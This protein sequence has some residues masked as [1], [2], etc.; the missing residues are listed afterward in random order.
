MLYL[1]HATVAAAAR[2]RHDIRL[3]TEDLSHPPRL[4][5]LGR[6]RNAGGLRAALHA[7]QLSQVVGVP[8]GQRGLRR[9]LVPGAGG[10]RR[11]HRTE[12][13]FLECAVGDPGG[14]A[15]H[16]P[17][18]LA[19]LVLRG[20]PRRGHGPAH[21]RC[22]LRLPGLHAHLADLRELHLHLL[23]ARSGHPRA[24]AADVPRL[25]AV[26]AVP[27]VVDRDHSAGGARHHADFGA[28]A[29]DAAD[30]DRAVRLPLHRGDG[31]EARAVCRLHR[32]RGPH[33]GQQRLRSTDVRRC[34]HGGLLARGAD[35][36][37]GR[38]PALS[39]REDCRQPRALVDGRAGRRAGL[40]RAGHAE[41]DGRR[42]PGLP[43][44]AARDTGQPRDRAHADVPHGLFVRA[45]RP[46]LGA[47]HHGAV[48]RR[49]ADEDQP[50][51]RLCGLAGVVELLC[52]A[53]AQPPGARGVA[54]VQ[55]GHRDPADGAGRVRRAGARAG[56]LQQHRHR[57]GRRAR[58]RPGHQQAAGLEPE[59]H[60]VQARAPVRHQPRGPGRD[61]GGGGVGDA[62]L[63]GRARPVGAGLLALHRAGHGHGRVAPAR[64]ADARAL[65]PGTY[66][67]R[68]LDA[69]PE[70]E[71]LGV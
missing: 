52:A 2:T 41:D 26:A 8:R 45:A 16:L 13:R 34:R 44:A 7:A 56:L 63:F 32:A 11:R 43:G 47:G 64:M 54:G 51:Q 5:R 50:D 12:L 62:G 33:L 53:H 19:H 35:R 3:R 60:R 29:V 21:A 14:R 10:H 70:R 48:R 69:G 6:E 58:G 18:G 30:L 31:E 71:M 40:D 39:A 49:V 38:L 15:H 67:H 20:A 22:R 17:H 1:P 36:R 66:R 55:R 46:G 4:Q 59:D 42:I 65:L 37:A 61:A 68:P 24:G 28:A 25:A 9:H 57:L 23:R 27:G